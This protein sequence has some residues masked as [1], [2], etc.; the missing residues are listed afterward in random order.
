MRQNERRGGFGP[1]NAKVMRHSE[2]HT[3]RAWTSELGLL[4]SIIGL[5]PQL[6]KEPSLRP[7]MHPRQRAA[8]RVERQARVA[9]GRVPG[10]RK[11]HRPGRPCRV[12]PR[13]ARGLLQPRTPHMPMS[14][15]ARTLLPLGP[16]VAEAAGPPPPR[17][18]RA[19]SPGTGR[20]NSAPSPTDPGS[21]VPGSG[22]LPPGLLGFLIGPR[23]LSPP[24]LELP[25]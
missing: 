19:S 7:W 18:R 25:S 8:L 16:C 24:H 4:C 1:L 17:G 9:R 14:L 5:T 12:F 6:P 2:Q 21:F 3:L 23:F 22:S 10:R 11:R 13:G 15:A 20:A